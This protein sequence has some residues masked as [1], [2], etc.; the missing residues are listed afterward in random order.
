MYRRPDPILAWHQHPE[1]A[2]A[3]SFDPLPCSGLHTQVVVGKGKAQ[4]IGYL[5]A[6]P[7]PG[8]R[9]AIPVF[10]DSDVNAYWDA[11]NP[12]NSTKTADYGTRIT[13]TG[14]NPGGTLSLTVDNTP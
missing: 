12:Q 13:V 14:Q 1:P 7:T 3:D 9:A 4:S 2:D 11:T 10:N 5:C 8:Q 6:W